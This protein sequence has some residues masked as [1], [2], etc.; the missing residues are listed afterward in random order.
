[1][2]PTASIPQKRTAPR[3]RVSPTE[4]W[5][6]VLIPTP[7]TRI[8]EVIRRESHPVGHPLREHALRDAFGV[9]RSPVC[10]ALRYLGQLRVVIAIPN[11]GFELSKAAAD[12]GS[13]DLS[14]HRSSEEELYLRIANNRIKGPLGD[15]VFEA[16]LMERHGLARL[17]LQRV[18]NAWRARA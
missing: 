16:D 3:E 6:S 9:S 15:E 1:M 4:P 18:L 14:A 7:A 17:P 12:L 11:R 10:E 5:V 13:L 8:V 2:M